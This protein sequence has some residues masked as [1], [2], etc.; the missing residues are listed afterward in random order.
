MTKL[1]DEDVIRKRVVGRHGA[2]EIENSTAT[3]GL[4]VRNNL[5]ELIGRELR[6]FAQ[7]VIVE[8]QHVAFGTEGVVARSQRRIVIDASR[9]ARDAGLSS[10]RTKSPDVEIFTVLFEW[11]SRKQRF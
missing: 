2:V 6:D 8:S 4:V 1:V 7:R 3:V 5:D 10:R 9:G 11:R